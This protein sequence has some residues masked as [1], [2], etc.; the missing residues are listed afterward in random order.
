MGEGSPLLEMPEADPLLVR[1]FILSGKC[2]SGGMGQSPLTWQ[3][4]DAL[5]RLQDL[6]LSPWD[7]E[8]IMMMS[9]VYLSTKQRASAD[10]SMLSPYAEETEEALNKQRESVAKQLKMLFK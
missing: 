1:A 8:Q 4:I 10:P 7:T 3:E 6:N 2:L 9:R 5:N